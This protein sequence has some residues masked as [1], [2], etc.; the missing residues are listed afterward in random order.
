MKKFIIN[1]ALLLVSISGYGQNYVDSIW[2]FVLNVY[3]VNRVQTKQFYIQNRTYSISIYGVDISV[4]LTP[5]FGHID[6][7]AYS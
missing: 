4:I 7:P 6:P 1:F 2:D 5:H 3:L